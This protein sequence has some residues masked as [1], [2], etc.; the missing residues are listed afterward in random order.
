MLV[1]FLSKHLTFIDYFNIQVT[2]GTHLI[3]CDLIDTVLMIPIRNKF[4]CNFTTNSSIGL[5]KGNGMRLSIFHYWCFISGDNNFI[6]FEETPIR[7]APLRNYISVHNFVI[8]MIT[9]F[10][11]Q[12]HLKTRLQWILHSHSI[13][14][15]QTKSNSAQ[16]IL[17]N[18][19]RGIFI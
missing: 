13:D 5:S 16:A 15:K 3:S 9:N 6:Y 17:M 11:M 2:R 1:F 4:S 19:Y 12:N 18:N 14:Y 8:T 10:G 7:M